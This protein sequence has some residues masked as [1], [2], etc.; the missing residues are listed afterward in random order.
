MAA[1][2][3]ARRPT[4][5]LG[6]AVR[7]RVKRRPTGAAA[8]AVATVLRRAAGVGRPLVVSL[9]VA[10]A[11][12]AVRAALQVP[13]AEQAQ[14]CAAAPPI[15]RAAPAT[16]P[17]PVRP[18]VEQAPPG[19]RPPVGA[20]RGARKRPAVVATAGARRAAARDV[21]VDPQRPV[22]V[23]VIAVKL[24]AVHG[25]LVAV[26][27]QPVAG[28]RPM[29]AAAPKQPAVAIRRVRRAG[30]AALAFAP[31]GTPAV[32]RQVVVVTTAPTRPRLLDRYGPCFTK[33]Q[34]GKPRPI[35]FCLIALAFSS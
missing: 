25:R 9:R 19:A 29:G 31:L 13:T 27:Q 12:A 30:A 28:P 14:A 4:A 33:L 5:A 32:G 16:R 11:G 17:I 22:L 10:D 21:P 2:V 1:T 24:P 20:V 3:R 7:A 18:A 6:D 8:Y 26:F 15:T 35:G 34:L 23:V